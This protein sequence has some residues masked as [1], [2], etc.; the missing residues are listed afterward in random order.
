MAGRELRILVQLEAGRELRVLALKRTAREHE[1]RVL[2]QKR[3]AERELRIWCQQH[4]L[5]P[6]FVDGELDVFVDD[7]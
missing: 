5:Q 1:H 3:E 7:Q 4:C 6:L 2:L